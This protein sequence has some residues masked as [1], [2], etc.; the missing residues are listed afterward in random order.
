MPQDY[1][2]T[3]Q[4][5]YLR[6][7]ASEDTEAERLLR[8][9]RDYAGGQQPVYLTERQKQFIGLDTRRGATAKGRADTRLYA[10]NLCQLVIDVLAERLSV[11]GFEPRKEQAQATRQEGDDPQGLCDWASEWWE[12]NRADALQDDV[13]EAAVRDGAAYLIVDWNAEEKRPRWSLNLALDGTRGMRV[14]RDPNTGDMLFAV[15]K[16]QVHDPIDQENNGRTR[17]TL[18]FPD[19]V[20]KYI[21]ALGANSGIGGT[22]WEPYSDS[23]DEPWPIPWKDRYGKPLGCAVVEFGNPPGAEI[24]QLMPL[25]DML[26]KADID[27]IACTDSAGFRI[28]YVAGVEA[29]IGADGVEKPITLSPGHIL[30]M[31]DHQAQ[32]GAIEPTDSQI[33]IETCKYWIESIAGVSRTPQYLFQPPGGTP[34]SGESLKQQETGLVHKVERRQRVFGNAWEDV[35]YLSAK[36]HNLY[37]SAQ[38][39]EIER[40]STLWAPAQEFIDPLGED[41]AEALIVKTQVEAG[42][43]LVT[44]LRERNWTDE[45]IAALQADMA[46]A[47][48]AQQQSLAAAL[49]DLE[50]RADRGESPAIVPDDEE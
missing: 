50:R 47:Q 18:Y 29:V 15:K 31:S 6:W 39:V 43:P 49:L 48:A 5:A 27:L 38:A 34:P 10:H 8:T 45:Q 35:I 33:L 25:Q 32:L 37:R 40:L 16:W 46:A 30:R 12:A 1:S 13:H 17:V 7:L 36:L 9:V 26:N 24:T 14:Y 41:Q 2:V 3:A 28:L 19:R 20:E 42:I 4:I 44:A 11:T 22:M 23:E 21:S